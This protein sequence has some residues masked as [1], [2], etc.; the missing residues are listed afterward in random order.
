M[1][2]TAALTISRSTTDYAAELLN[3]YSFGSLHYRHTVDLGSYRFKFDHCDRL[4]ARR[5]DTD[6]TTTYRSITR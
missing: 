1:T 3:R 4:I 2:N 6:R 5:I